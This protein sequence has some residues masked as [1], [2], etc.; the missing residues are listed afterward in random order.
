MHLLQGCLFHL[1]QQVNIRVDSVSP[2]YQIYFVISCKGNC[3]RDS[4][5]SRDPMVIL[6]HVRE[7]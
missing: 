6:L 7:M 4:Q 5:A 2:K 3:A 1:D